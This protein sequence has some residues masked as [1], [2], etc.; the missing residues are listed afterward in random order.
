VDVAVSLTLTRGGWRALKTS[1]ARFLAS[2][3]SLGMTAAATATK[4]GHTR[5]ARRR[6]RRRSESGR[7]TRGGGVV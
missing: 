1:T 7:R 3:R 4:N 6:S 5:M 2:L